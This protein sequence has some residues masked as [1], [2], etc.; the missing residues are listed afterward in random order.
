MFKHFLITRFNLRKDSWMYDKEKTVVLTDEWHDNRFKLFTQYC[1]ESVNSQ[2]NQNFEW[3]VFFDTTTPKKYRDYIS[4]L[5]QEMKN[6]KPLFVDGMEQFLPSIHSYIANYKEE[7]LIT[8]RIDNDDC[9]NKLYI[10]EVQ[11][12][13]NNQNFMAIDFID[14]YTLQI[15][16]NVKL[17]KRLDQYNPFISLIEKNTNPKSVWNVRHSHWKK[18][19]NIIQIKG[20]RLW[21]SIIHHE[22]K[23]NSFIGFGTINLNQFFQNFSIKEEQ[24]QYIKA[25]IIPKNQWK[26]LSLK[27]V[28]KS[29]TN[30]Y[31]KNIKKHLGI[32]KN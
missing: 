14:G 3:L 26:L 21:T 22:N 2:T 13:F 23:I 20:L 12:R 18:E 15:Q 29:Y 25:N 9:I 32:Y 10:N 6:F 5:E 16:P 31:Y 8:S 27:N 30:L 1:F 28:Y 17:A 19:K 24:V 4:S 11:K 7:Y